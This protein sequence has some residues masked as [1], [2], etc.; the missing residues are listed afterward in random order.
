MLN[1]L[2]A[3]WRAAPR[4]GDI[5]WARVPYADGTGAKLRPCLV[6]R[7]GRQPVVLKI[8]SRD[9]SH[10][11]DHVP[12]TTS[13]WDPW[14]R[15]DSYLNL[16]E[17]IRVPRDAFQ[18]RAGRADRVTRAVVRRLGRTGGRPGR[19]TPEGRDHRR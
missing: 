15:R 18:R 6:L 17:P 14:A 13:A 11:R 1:R 3:W 10:R 4:R 5:W 2:L 12:I 9:K 8:T 7:G 19:R 16:A